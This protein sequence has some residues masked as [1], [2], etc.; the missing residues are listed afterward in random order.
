MWR[1]CVTWSICNSVLI[2]PN[3]CSKLMI[4]WLNLFKTHFWSAFKLIENS[5]L[6]Q[7]E[8]MKVDQK[9]VFEQF[10]DHVT[11]NYSITHFWSTFISSNWKWVF[12]QFESESKVGFRT[13]W[14]TWS[15]ISNRNSGGS[16]LSWQNQ[17][18]K[19]SSM[20][21]QEP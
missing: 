4:T 13:N 7:F 16:K 1:R 10:I 8:L 2:H 19:F 21:N 20:K 3:F 12:D 5:L 9:W 15:L 6:I 17:R 18:E 11:M 14:V